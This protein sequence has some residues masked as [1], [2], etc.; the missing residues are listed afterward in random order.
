MDGPSHDVICIRV[1]PENRWLYRYGWEQV[2]CHQC[3]RLVWLSKVNQNR[4]RVGDWIR[5]PYVK[6]I[7]CGNCWPKVKKR[8]SSVRQKKTSSSPRAL[9]TTS[10]QDSK[11]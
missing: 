4:I 9:E 8:L 11:S 5:F 3:D 2:C 6:G 7:Y 10:P 1:R